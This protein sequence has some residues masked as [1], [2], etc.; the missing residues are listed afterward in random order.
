MSAIRRHSRKEP[1]ALFLASL[2]GD[3]ICFISSCCLCCD[4]SILDFSFIVVVAVVERGIAYCLDYT[5]KNIVCRE[6]HEI[7]SGKCLWW[8]SLH[9]SYDAN[10][11]LF[12][13]A[14]VLLPMFLCVFPHPQPHQLY[15]LSQNAL[16][17]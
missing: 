1:H 6:R 11:S 8:A 14:V 7:G 13:K 3:P 15:K 12:S 2:T 16:S 9:K 5:L 4:T 10:V 17:S